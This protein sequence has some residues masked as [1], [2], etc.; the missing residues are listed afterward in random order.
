LDSAH[1]K[2]NLF[3]SFVAALV[4]PRSGDGDAALVGHQPPL[5]VLETAREGIVVLDAAGTPPDEVG[6]RAGRIVGGQQGGHLYLVVV[7][8]GAELEP[9]LKAVDRDAPDP[10][11]LSMFHL[12][13]AGRLDRLAGAR[14]TA[15]E[16]AARAAPSTPPLQVA[17]VP[18]LIAR[19]RRE[20]EEAIHFAA[21][22]RGR[23]PWATIALVAVC[24]LVFLLDSEV[25]KSRGRWGENFGEWVK[26]GEVWRLLS[27][28]FPSRLM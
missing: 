13:D 3:D 21:Q 2:E 20:R 4:T 22:F 1:R 26:A 18:A 28:A 6:R 11:R 10:R 24:V 27:S 9:I 19:G 25:W 12:D 23:R 8:G 5:A 7:G 14:S 15:I 17:D 16:R